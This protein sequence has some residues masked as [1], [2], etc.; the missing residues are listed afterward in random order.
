MAGLVRA[1]LD[2]GFQS[3]LGP[4]LGLEHGWGSLALQAAEVGG[5]W[6]VFQSRGRDLQVTT[7]SQGL[8]QSGPANG[9]NNFNII[10]NELTEFIFLQLGSIGFTL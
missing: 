10:I 6:M 3:G 1:S 8:Q 4:G 9:F 5:R 7:A 2:A